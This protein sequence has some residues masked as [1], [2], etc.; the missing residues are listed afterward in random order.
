MNTYVFAQCIRRWVVPEN[1]KN[2]QNNSNL[3]KYKYSEY[4][5]EVISISF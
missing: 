1:K 2:L 3:L 4:I 5:I